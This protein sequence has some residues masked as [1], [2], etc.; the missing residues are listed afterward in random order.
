MKN[1]IPISTQIIQLKA[2]IAQLVRDMADVK[3][4]AKHV[5]LLAALKQR[6]EA[7]LKILEKQ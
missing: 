6:K 1:S 4:T 5:E 7:A 2:Q 3:K